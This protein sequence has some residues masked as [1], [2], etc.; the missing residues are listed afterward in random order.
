MS[1]TEFAG[2]AA[3]ALLIPGWWTPVGGAVQALAEGYLAFLGGTLDSVHL[4]RCLMGI[5]LI[6][7]GPGAW[8]IDAR[9][10]GR[11]RIEVGGRQ[12]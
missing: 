7:L 4:M 8:S 11:K 12:D 6:M 9:L 5:S 1:W 2:V 10:Y 3:S